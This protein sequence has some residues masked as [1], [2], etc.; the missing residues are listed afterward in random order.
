M[1]MR[2]GLAAQCQAMRLADDLAA[3]NRIGKL[4]VPGRDCLD[5]VTRLTMLSKLMTPRLDRT[6]H[7][8]SVHARFAMCDRMDREDRG[9]TPFR[10][11]RETA[12]SSGIV[13]ATQVIEQ[14]LDLDFDLVVSDLAPIDLMI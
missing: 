9:A 3:I 2:A 1:A 7:P 8:F 10:Q 4:H 6:L 5:F 13:V 12:G 11:K 14:S